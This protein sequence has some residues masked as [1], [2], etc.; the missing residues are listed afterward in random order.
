MYFEYCL[1]LRVDEVQEKVSYGM[2]VCVCVCVYIYIYI[3]VCVCVCVLATSQ[4][5]LPEL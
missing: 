1:E 5:T 4:Y 3:C 2:C